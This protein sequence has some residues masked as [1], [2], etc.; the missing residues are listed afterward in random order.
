MQH[1]V[2]PLTVPRL[3]IAGQGF[4]PERKRRKK[5]IPPGVS[6]FSV[7]LCVSPKRE[8]LSAYGCSVS[9]AFSA[10][11]R[12]VFSGNEVAFA[13]VSAVVQNFC[14]HVSEKAVAVGGVFSGIILFLCRGCGTVFLCVQFFLL[15]CMTNQCVRLCILAQTRVRCNI[16]GN[17]LLPAGFLLFLPAVFPSF[18]CQKHAESTH[19]IC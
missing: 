3:P 2:C 18:S 16:S 1:R 13:A 19:P 6:F 7:F 5:E 8:M 9:G 4:I 11:K 12:K 10:G 17:C 15:F 14:G